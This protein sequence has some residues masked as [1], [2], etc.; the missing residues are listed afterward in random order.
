VI[1]LDKRHAFKMRKPVNLG[2][3]DYST[4]RARRRCSRLE[5]E[6]GQRVSPH[7]YRG[8]AFLHRADS[9]Y[10]LRA[11]PPGEPVVQMVRLPHE[12]RLDVV[13]SSKDAEPKRLR[14]LVAQIAAFHST[15]PCDRRRKGWGAIAHIRKAWDINFSQLP[16]SNRTVALT[17]SERN[18]LI[19]ETA[20]WFD[21][22]GQVLEQRVAE[23]RVREGHGDL[24]SGHIYL[25]PRLTT[26]D[27]LEFSRALRF[28]DVA[29]EIGFL[30]MEFDAIGRGDVGT[31]ITAEYAARARDN[32]LLLVSPLFKRYRAVVRA[33]VEW[34]RSRQLRGRAAASHL[35]RSRRLFE[36]AMS[37]AL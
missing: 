31:F 12:R 5:I 37:Y 29:A 15:A 10:H 9:E 24:R 8:V 25:Y 3:L 11:R 14:K 34:I 19:R 1:V 16:E 21:R 26:I 20:D 18:H 6:L 17:A 7:V 36:L 32:S 33:K 22:L 13:F 4:P 35:A 2:F 28:T 27:P 30:A 23:G